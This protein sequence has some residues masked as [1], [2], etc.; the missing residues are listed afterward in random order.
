MGFFYLNYVMPQINASE[1]QDYSLP[2]NTQ[3]IDNKPVVNKKSH[4]GQ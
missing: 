2:V 1:K 3:A 4:P